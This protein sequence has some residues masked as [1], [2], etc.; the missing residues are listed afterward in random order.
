MMDDKRDQ[1]QFLGL[2]TMPVHHAKI[3]I[4]GNTAYPRVKNFAQAMHD[5]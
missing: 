3:V 5:T 4:T 1:S 2:N